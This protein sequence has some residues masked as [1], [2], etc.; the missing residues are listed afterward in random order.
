MSEAVFRIVDLNCGQQF[1]AGNFRI[2]KAFGKDGGSQDKVAGF[3]GGKEEKEDKRHGTGDKED[4][5]AKG[6]REREK[7][8]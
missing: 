2:D 4:P 6:E 3:L 5:E 8:G 1:L 7:M